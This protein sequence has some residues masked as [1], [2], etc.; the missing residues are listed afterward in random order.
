MAMA[1][2]DPAGLHR[3][4]RLVRTSKGKRAKSFAKV[5]G[6]SDG[7]ID[8]QCLFVQSHSDRRSH[9]KPN[10]KRTERSDRKDV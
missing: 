9:L 6:P 7:G 3:S 8:S 10:R 5:Y 2:A 4:R 1:E